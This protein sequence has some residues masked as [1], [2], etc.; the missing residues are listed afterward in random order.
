MIQ[1]LNLEPDDDGAPKPGAALYIGDFMGDREL[2]ITEGM[3]REAARDFPGSGLC[4]FTQLNDETGEE[5]WDEGEGARWQRL[6]KWPR[7]P[8]I[9]EA[10]AWQAY[11]NARAK[12]ALWYA[13][14][15][16]AKE[17]PW[18]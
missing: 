3:H 10:M 2:L 12:A 17:Q 13:V 1:D 14:N 15:G 16:K 9:E 4:M 18:D 7:E 11:I 6:M 8:T 5:F